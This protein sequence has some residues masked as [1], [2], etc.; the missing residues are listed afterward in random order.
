VLLEKRLRPPY[1]IK[2]DVQG[3]ELDVLE[4]GQRALMSA[5]AVSLEVS[6][7]QFFKG[8]PQLSEVVEYMKKRDF[9]VFDVV[10]AASWR[11]PR[12]IANA[13]PV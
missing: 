12:V 11:L 8:G 9:V 4:G 10:L 2:V 7:F 5:E 3:G 6:L 13:F 1:L